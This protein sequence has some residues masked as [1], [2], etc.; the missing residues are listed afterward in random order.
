M[1]DVLF[2]PTI[3]AKLLTADEVADLWNVDVKT[4]W[5]MCREKRIVHHRFGRAY[6]FHPADIAAIL[7]QTRVDVEVP[8]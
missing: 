8:R 1:T 6:R 2:M 5:T 7:E 4:I 3:P